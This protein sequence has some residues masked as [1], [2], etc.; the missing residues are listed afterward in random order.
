MIQFSADDFAILTIDGFEARMALLRG[1][2]S[3]KLQALGEALLPDLVSAIGIPFHVHVARHQRRTVNPPKDTWVALSDNARGYKMA[4]HFEFG[5]F[6]D[7]FF[8][9]VGVLYEAN[10]RAGFA[11]VASAYAAEITPPYHFV[12]DHL[13]SAAA[14]Q[15]EVQAVRSEIHR[16]LGRKQGDIL[17]ERRFAPSDMGDGDAAERIRGALGPLTDLYVSWYA[18]ASAAAGS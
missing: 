7:Y 18:G 3:P 6:A 16:Q 14:P 12:F 1:R 9:R 11:E 13:T 2:L 10:D 17:V 15:H 8:M 4:P 5:L